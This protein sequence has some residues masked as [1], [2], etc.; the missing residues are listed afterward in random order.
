[1]MQGSLYEAFFLC[2]LRMKATKPTNASKKM[3]VPLDNNL[4]LEIYVI[5]TYMLSATRQVRF[6]K[7][8]H[9]AFSTD[10]KY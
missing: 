5:C 9:C 7:L 1:M 2:V 10:E 4:E 8:K 6:V 3:R